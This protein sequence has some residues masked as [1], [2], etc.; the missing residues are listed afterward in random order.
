MKGIFWT[1]IPESIIGKVAPGEQGGEHQQHHP[2][3]DVRRQEAVQRDRGR[4]GGEDDP[5]ADPARAAPPAGCRTR[6]APPAPCLRALQDDAGDDRP[7]RD[8]AQ[9]VEEFLDPLVDRDA[10]QVEDED[11]ERD[12][13]RSRA[14]SGPG[15]GTAAGAHAGSVSG[16]K[17]GSKRSAEVGWRYEERGAPRRRALLGRRGARIPLLDSAMRRLSY[18]RPRP[19]LAHGRRRPRAP[20]R[21]LPA[22]G[23]LAAASSRS[24]SPPPPRT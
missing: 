22:A 20:R 3:A 8:L 11:R 2:G 6:R 23:R 4:V 17:S 10:E 9:L 18:C 24:A 13:R 21:S 7:G 16:G 15:A 14:R 1:T 19:A 12:R 5:V